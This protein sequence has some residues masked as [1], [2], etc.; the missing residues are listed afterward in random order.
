MEKKEIESLFFN[1][2]PVNIL[3]TIYKEED[4]AYTLN[5][6]HELKCSYSHAV[7][8]ISKMEEIGILCSKFRGRKKTLHLTDEGKRLAEDIIN[9]FSDDIQISPKNKKEEDNKVENKIKDI[10]NKVEKIFKEEINSK[11]SITVEDSRRIG[12]RL[13]PYK[14]ELS[15]ID[16]S[17]EKIGKKVSELK[18][19][20]DEIMD[21]REPLLGD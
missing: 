19:Y 5:I 15:K 12:K 13:G 6:S 14:R 2:I 7:K 17:K 16:T 10:E 20:I 4:S 9:V 8:T 21:M 3:T 11:D 18:D 1:E